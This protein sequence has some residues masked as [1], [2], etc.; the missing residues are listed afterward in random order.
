MFGLTVQDRNV[1]NQSEP[2]VIRHMNPSADGRRF[3][4]KL[5]K[6]SG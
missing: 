5:K 2:P 4:Q 3:A 1:K 6:P